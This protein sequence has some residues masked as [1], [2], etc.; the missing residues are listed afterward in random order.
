MSLAIKITKLVLL[1]VIICVANELAGV[2]CSFDFAK[3][4]VVIENRMGDNSDITLQCKSADDDLGIHVLHV[5]QRFEFVFRPNFWGS[6]LFVCGC[7]SNKG[8]VQWKAFDYDRDTDR[9]GVC[10]WLVIQAY[11]IGLDPSGFDH[12]RYPWK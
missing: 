5:G 10:V 4:R 8:L 9:C 1:Y 2:D 7:R 6:T 12:I 11:V 3:R